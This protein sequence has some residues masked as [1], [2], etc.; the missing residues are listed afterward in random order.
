MAPAPAAVQ[1]EPPAFERQ[2]ARPAPVTQSAAAAAAAAR[3]A[4]P[5]QA[6]RLAAAPAQARTPMTASEAAAATL[7]SALLE[8]LRLRGE[9][10]AGEAQQRLDGLRQRYSEILLQQ[11]LVELGS[12]PQEQ[13]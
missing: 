5:E 2:L 13:P 6:K 10:R 9:G 3:P 1:A 7:D 4:P 12:T 8:I 11:R